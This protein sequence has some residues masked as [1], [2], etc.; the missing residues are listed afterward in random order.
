M[1][2]K[3]LIA[4][5]RMFHNVFVC[6]VCGKKIRTQMMRIL[7]GKIK[8]PRCTGHAFRPVRKK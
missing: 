3:I 6:K 7:A 5:K 4:Q 2:T 1:A 8:C